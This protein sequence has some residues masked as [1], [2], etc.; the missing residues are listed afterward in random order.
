[1]RLLVLALVSAFSPV[2]GPWHVGHV[3]SHLS[4]EEHRRTIIQNN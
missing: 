1:M 3:L 4:A 2:S